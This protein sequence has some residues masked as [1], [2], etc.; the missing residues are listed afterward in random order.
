MCDMA[1]VCKRGGSSN[2]FRCVCVSFLPRICLCLSVCA[3]VCARARA[4]AC[5]CVCVWKRP[6][7]A[8][9][10]TLCRE[11]EVQGG[12]CRGGHAGHVAH[13]ASAEVAVRGLAIGAP[14]SG[15]LG[16]VKRDT[17]RHRHRALQRLSGVRAVPA[18]R[19]GLQQ[20]ALRLKGPQHN[21]QPPS[22]QPRA[23]ATLTTLPTWN[24]TTHTHPLRSDYCVARLRRAVAAGR[25]CR[26][27]VPTRD[28]VV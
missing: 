8:H 25:W 28:G 19:V 2:H 14:S 17:K 4:R 10:V 23:L 21:R 13:G 5:V 7:E 26:S 15:R 9:R 6:G 20:G 3:R 22:R 1:G 27:M 12:R 24:P 16:H 18:R 11:R